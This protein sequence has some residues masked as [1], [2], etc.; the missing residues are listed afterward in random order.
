MT[1]FGDNLAR[2]AD[3]AKVLIKNECSKNFK[4]QVCK[5]NQKRD[6]VEY[7]RTFGEIV[8]FACQAPL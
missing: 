2:F 7:F 4:S 6:T 8:N 3:L 5:T 1:F